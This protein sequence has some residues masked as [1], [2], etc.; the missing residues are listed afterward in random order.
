[1]SPIVPLIVAIIAAIIAIVALILIFVLPKDQGP[2]GPPGPTGG[3]GGGSGSTIIAN[4]AGNVRGINALRVDFTGQSVTVPLKYNT[5]ENVKNITYDNTTGEF[6]V[7]QTGVYNINAISNIVV[8]VT[9]P[10]SFSGNTTAYMDIQ[11]NG[12]TI[13]RSGFRIFMNGIY[14]GDSGYVLLTNNAQVNLTNGQR[15]SI[16]LTIDSPYTGYMLYSYSDFSRITITGS[17]L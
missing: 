3:G 16:K 11:V 10:P 12:T 8:N 15:V 1:M 17:S 7:R 5:V 13:A 2:T 4:I 6:T 14:Y 9:Q